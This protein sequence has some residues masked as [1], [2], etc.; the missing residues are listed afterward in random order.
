L[1]NRQFY[2]YKFKSSRLKEFN[3]NVQLTFEEAQEYGEVISLFD[4]QM[5]RSIRQIHNRE[6]DNEQLDTLFSEKDYLKHL[7][8]SQENVDLIK[9]IQS[10]INDLLFIPEYITIVMDHPSHYKYLYKNKLQLNG[11]FFVRF[12]SSAGQARNST[13]VFVEEETAKQLDLILNNGRNLNKELVPSKFNAYKGLSGSAT[14]VVSTPRFCV[15]P[16]YESESKVKVNF[17][18]ETDLNEDDVIET[19]EITEMFNRFDGQGLIS[20]EMASK[21]AAELELD[22]VPAQWCVRQNFIK[23]MLNTFPIHEFCEK[24]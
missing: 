22:Y 2:T 23:G 8:H 19:K 10:Q 21:W 15:V 5:L 18:T 24:V 12:S 6:L 9:N 11:K 7:S 3:Y 17:V 16:D 1:Q 20:Y 13:V 14:Q 4:N